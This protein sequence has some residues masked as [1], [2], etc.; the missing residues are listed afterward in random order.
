M[1]NGVEFVNLAEI[2]RKFTDD[3]VDEPI[4]GMYESLGGA[5][6]GQLGQAV[7]DTTQMH[8]GRLAGDWSYNKAELQ[9]ETPVPYARFVD[10]GTKHIVRPR[11]FVQKAIKQ[12]KSDANKAVDKASREIERKWDRRG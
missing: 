6:V 11:R 12:S 3:L 2:K 8:S 10:A 9:V 7:R 5:V 4:E 1:F